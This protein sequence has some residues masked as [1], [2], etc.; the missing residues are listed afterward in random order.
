MDK[1]GAFQLFDDQKTLRV[2]N[3]NKNHE[4]RYSCFGK[5]SFD[6]VTR[7]FNVKIEMFALWSPFTNWTPCSEACGEGYQI[8]TRICVLPTGVKVSN[9]QCVGDES[10]SRKCTEK[11]CPIDGEWSD[12]GSLSP[13]SR[14]CGTGYQVKK[15]FCDNPKPQHDGRKC[16]GF[17]EEYN[18]CQN[19]PC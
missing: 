13:C 10:E 7:N 4:G 1:R 5:N 15:R 2:S 17:F 18:Y 16:E 6:S 11:P 14:T 19:K 8:R 12:W 3:V 9:E